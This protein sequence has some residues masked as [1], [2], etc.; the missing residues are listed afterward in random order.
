MNEITEPQEPKPEQFHALAQHPTLGE[1]RA[2]AYGYWLDVLSQ[3]D[4]EPAPG[5]EENLEITWINHDEW[6]FSGPALRKPLRKDP[7]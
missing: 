4:G 2:A 5:A 3:Y 6:V 7:T 1:D